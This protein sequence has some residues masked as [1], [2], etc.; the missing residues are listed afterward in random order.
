MQHLTR[1]FTLCRMALLKASARSEFQRLKELMLI[2]S[3]SSC[4]YRPWSFRWGEGHPEA[5][6]KG[7]VAIIMKRAETF[8][9]DREAFVAMTEK[10]AWLADT[11]L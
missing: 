8:V 10:P 3:F 11:I 1:T 7:D 6:H 5:F 2:I 4:G 9:Q